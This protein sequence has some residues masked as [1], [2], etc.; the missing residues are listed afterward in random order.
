[1][2]NAE[3]HNEQQSDLP[4][5]PQMMRPGVNDVLLRSSRLINVANNTDECHQNPCR[6]HRPAVRINTDAWLLVSHKLITSEIT[7]PPQS[8]TCLTCHAL[9][10][11]IH[12]PPSNHTSPL[13]STLE[14][15]I[16][17]FYWLCPS[18]IWAS[19]LQRSYWMYK[20]YLVI[21]HLI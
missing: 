3:Q 7:P 5:C 17:Y 16:G 8:G 6:L 4:H 13:N 1:M 18:W 14:D 11:P 9:I 20:L 2:C 10:G 21:D 19:G 15:A 12:R